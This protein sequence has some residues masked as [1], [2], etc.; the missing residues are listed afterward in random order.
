MR[1]YFAGRYFKHQKDGQTICFIVGGASGGK[2]LQVITNDRILQYDDLKHCHADR[3][4]F[5]VSLPEIHGKVTYGPFT[6]I[7]SDIMGPFRALPMQCRHEIISMGHS[8]TGGF[9]IDGKR[10]DLNGGKGY[11]EGDRGRSFPKEYL[12]LH[13]ND[14]AENCS[15]MASVADIPFC[16]IHFMGCIC[17]V[18]YQGKEYRLATYHGVRILAADD[19]R[20]ILRQGPLR[21]EAWI[22][23]RRA[24]P[25]KAPKSGRMTQ[26][27]HESNCSRARFRFW[28]GK[29]RLFDMT[30]E[31]CSFECNLHNS[32][33][34]KK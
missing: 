33:F 22:D 3:N 20:L 7:R 27:I 13:C 32:K 24:H 31:N 9:T 5:S 10:I 6:P 11:I 2:F 8:L 12:W 21:L 23:P 30:S 29:K 26:T 1:K 15:I 17:A 25:L 18:L 16:G 19:R 14:F 4:G 28:T 34:S